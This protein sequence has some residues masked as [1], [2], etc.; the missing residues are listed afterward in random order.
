MDVRL[1]LTEHRWHDLRTAL[2]A[3]T[4]RFAD[5]LLSCRD[6]DLPAIGHWS[7]AE[8]AAHAAIVSRMQAG[9]LRSPAAPLGVPEIDRLLASATL[10]DFARLND[11]ALRAFPE[12]SPEVLARDLREGVADVVELSADADPHR[13]A[14][15]LGDSRMPVASLLAHQL[16]EILLHGWDIARAVSLPWR[17]PSAEAALAFEVFLVQLLGGE[18]TGHLFGDGSGRGRRLR[19]EFR[20]AHTT[21]VVLV[22]GEGRVGADPPGGGADARVRF[23]PGALMLTVFRRTPLARAVA[24][25][26]IVATGPRPWVAVSYLR[27]MRTP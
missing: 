8:V 6:P 27:R 19:V 1:E 23:E 22:S 3:A 7:V 4:E 24:T 13:S 16:N 11:A 21:P 26:R 10:G 18:H 20:S 25:G 5:L 12:R 9:F 17:V 14:R 2:A 15:W